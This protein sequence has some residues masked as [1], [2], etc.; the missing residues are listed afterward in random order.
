MKKWKKYALRMKKK[1]AY[2]MQKD[3]KSTKHDKKRSKD[4]YKKWGFHFEEVWS[5]D[6]SI[7][8]Y[9]LPRL[10]YL[11]EYHAGC[12]SSLVKM[13]NNGKIIEKDNY[14]PHEEWNNILDKM[15]YSFEAIADDYASI[16]ANVYSDPKVKEGLLLFAVHFNSLW[17]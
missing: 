7:A 15:I 3:P 11:R 8:C 1:G 12:P 5:L 14:D 4:F 6:H 13:D 17:D 10:A 9:I 16:S 2:N